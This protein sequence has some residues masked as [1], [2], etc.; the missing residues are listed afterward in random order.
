MSEKWTAEIIVSGGNPDGW[1]HVICRTQGAT[2]AA[3]LEGANEVSALFTESYPT[4][5]RAHPEANTEK[6]FETG[7]VTNHGFAR[8]SIK[9]DISEDALET[10][11][12]EIPDTHP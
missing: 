2:V 3:A 8:F 12:I 5:W 10:V 6:N 11:E 1:V 9:T 7:S 4:E